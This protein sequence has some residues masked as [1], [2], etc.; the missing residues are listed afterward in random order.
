MVSASFPY[1]KPS[2]V[3]PYCTFTLFLTVGVRIHMISM[4][5]PASRM[6]KLLP[7]YHM[8][9]SSVSSTEM[10]KA[11]TNLPISVPAETVNLIAWMVSLL[12]RSRSARSICAALVVSSPAVKFTSGFAVAVPV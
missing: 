6:T 3:L 11:P 1:Q 5:L 7:W 9:S 2:M 8:V 4:F 12:V 10:P